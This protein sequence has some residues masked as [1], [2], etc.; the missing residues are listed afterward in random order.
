M[1]T[2]ALAAGYASSQSR[3]D[4]HVVLY[5]LLSLTIELSSC[6][7]KAFNARRQ[8]VPVWADSVQI[9]LVT[10]MALGSSAKPRVIARRKRCQ[11]PVDKMFRQ[12][13]AGVADW[14]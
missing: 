12:K 4:R 2:P 8:Y 1:A 6:S 14:Q 13:C 3:H 7:G 11:S 5:G 10:S 9:W